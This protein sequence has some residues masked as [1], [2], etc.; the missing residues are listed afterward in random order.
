MEKAFFARKKLNIDRLGTYGFTEAKEGYA[1]ATDILDGQFHMHIAITADGQLRTQL[2]DAA[3]GEEYT[4]HRV[5]GASGAFVGRV[6]EAWEEVLLDIAANCFEPDVFKHPQTRHVIEY[7]RK[8]YGDEP[9]FLWQRF[10]DNAVL[11]R[12]DTGKWYAA[13]LRLPGSKLGLPTDEIIEILDLRLSPEEMEATVDHVRF[14]PG[15]HMNK[16]HWYTIC[17]N[18]SVPADEICRRI[19]ASYQ[20]SAR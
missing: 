14:F 10:P 11:R 16:K 3:T 15:Y 20:L 18:E 1:Y 2:I 9:E 12:K 13:L 4:L 17:L 7:V 8:T 6:R 19:A 5:A